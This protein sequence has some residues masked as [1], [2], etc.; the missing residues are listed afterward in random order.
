MTLE[1]IY[2]GKFPIMIQSDL[3]ILKGMAP[4]VRKNMGEDPN[5]P[6]FRKMHLNLPEH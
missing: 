2:M 5:D 4:Q 1:K 3:C 6:G